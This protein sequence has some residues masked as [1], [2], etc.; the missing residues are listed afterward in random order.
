MHIIV[1]MYIHVYIYTFLPSIPL[2]FFPSLLPTTSLSLSPQIKAASEKLAQLHTST[3]AS[4][5]SQEDKS[6]SSFANAASP[7]GMPTASSDVLEAQRKRFEELKVSS[8]QLILPLPFE[9]IP[10]PPPLPPP[11]QRQAR[12]S[13]STDGSPAKDTTSKEDLLFDQIA[14][15]SAAKTSAI[16]YYVH[17]YVYNTLLRVQ[18]ITTCT[19]HYYMYNTLLHV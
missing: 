12:S 13:T 10:P 14:T 19:I 1:H 17:Y 16:H 7:S 9:F 4:S 15:S 2:F 3:L 11:R 8:P 6:S 18:Y 5:S